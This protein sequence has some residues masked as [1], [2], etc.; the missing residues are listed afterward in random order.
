MSLPEIIVLVKDNQWLFNLLFSF[1][2]A[3]STVFY[4][5]LTRILTKETKRLREAQTE[6]HI[7]IG[8]D[9][10]EGWINFSKIVVQ[11]T[12]Q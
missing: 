4:V 8:F 10:E 6:P 11:N 9:P 3:A 5:F 1:V 7:S 2:V 12:G